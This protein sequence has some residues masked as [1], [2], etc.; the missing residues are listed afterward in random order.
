MYLK[1]VQIIYLM[2]EKE[3]IKETGYYLL[4]KPTVSHNNSYNHIK[5]GHTGVF[6]VEV[7]WLKSLCSLTPGERGAKINYTSFNNNSSCIY[8]SHK[9]DM[10]VGREP[11]VPLHR[12]CST[13][14]S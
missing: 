8:L 9:S 5:Q 7:H 3:K 14:E 1:N 12:E 11:G 6:K 10:K 13:F 4:L 2:E